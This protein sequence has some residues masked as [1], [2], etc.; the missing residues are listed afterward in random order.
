MTSRCNLKCVHCHAFGGEP[1]LRED[2]FDLIAYAKS[3]GFTVFIATNGTL[4]TKEVAKL[5]REFDVGVVIGVDAM[6]PEIHDCI[7]GVEGAYDAVMEGIENCIAENLYLH[8]N[9]VASRPNF[10]EIEKII[11]YSDKIGVYSYFIYNFVPFG[12][13]EEIRDY[14]LGEE[15]FKALLDLIHEKQR[16]VRAIIIPVAFLRRL[17]GG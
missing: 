15:D 9:I 2:L 11:D 16:E 14:E 1:L 8:L 13:G 6:N 7:R 3:T 12:R 5:L 4:I 10:D 17:S